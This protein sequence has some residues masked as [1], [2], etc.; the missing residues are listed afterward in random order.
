[1]IPERMER[2]AETIKIEVSDIIRRRIRDNR[3]GFVTVTGVKVSRDL[4]HAR[5]FVSIMGEEKE[6]ARGLKG[7]SSAA[8]YVRKILGERLDIRYVPEINFIL[9]RSVDHSF[10]IESILRKIE[11]ERKK[12]EAE[13]ADGGTG[14]GEEG[15]AG[16]GGGE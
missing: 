6:K 12:S 7:L 14:E 15:G 3:V 5:V 8:G 11:S 9:D 2:V 13:K 4:R 1:M 10:R 16:K